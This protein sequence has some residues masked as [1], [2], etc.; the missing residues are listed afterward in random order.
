MAAFTALISFGA[1][2]VVAVQSYHTLIATAVNILLLCFSGLL[3]ANWN[4]LDSWARYR[5][6]SCFFLPPSPRKG[7]GFPYTAQRFK[8]VL[9]P[10]CMQINPEVIGFYLQTAFPPSRLGSVAFPTHSR[11]G[12][13]LVW[14][15]TITLGQ[16]MKN[17]H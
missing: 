7:S 3:I 17:P 8:V 1:K 6:Q 2:D 16:E 11:S 13:R 15:S 5:F 12:E 9:F 10:E 14:T 4:I